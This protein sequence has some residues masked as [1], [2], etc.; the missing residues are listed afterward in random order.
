M[1]KAT[2]REPEQVDDILADFLGK[3]QS[4]KTKA[5][6]ARPESV[7]GDEELAPDS[8]PMP[9][10]SARIPRSS[11]RPDTARTDVQS[12]IDREL[13]SVREEDLDH[14]YEAEG[15]LDARAH[16]ASVH[17]RS[18]EDQ[19]TNP[20]VHPRS[21][22]AQTTDRNNIARG[23]DDVVTE[24]YVPPVRPRPRGFDEA[25]VVGRRPRLA[26][27]SSWKHVFILGSIITSG[28]VVLIVGLWLVLS[29]RSPDT[30][31]PRATRTGV[32]DHEGM[33]GPR[34]RAPAKP[35]HR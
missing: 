15:E 31:A 25:T 16:L 22:D 28:L 30:T 2:N 35:K 17:P 9:T 34:P 23:F 5:P 13:D 32:S 26:A 11:K 14:Q 7:F 19:T 21:R 1:A 4:T 6:V 8:V 29:S 33:D 3:P 20:S 24:P 18:H 27:P 10:A 12:M